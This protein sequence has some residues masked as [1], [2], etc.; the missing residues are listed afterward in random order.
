MTYLLCHGFGFTHEYWR[1]FVP[2]L[3]KDDVEF[4]DENFVPDEKKIYV[5]VG[6]SLGFLMLNNSGIKFH[7]LIGLQ[8]FLNFCGSDPEKN[9]MLKTNLDRMILSFKQ[10]LK[11]SLEFFYNFCGYGGSI[12]KNLSLEQLIKELE[13][14]KSSFEHCKA[15]TLIIGSY[16]D[17]VVEKDILIDN[18]QNKDLI[19]LKFLD[20]AVHS[21]G[22]QQPREVFNLIQTFLAEINE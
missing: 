10:D 13:M 8:G 16:D 20:K 5:G 7:A 6:H 12:P 11:R 19:T 18:F 22:Y 2:L 21:L 1:N 9:N 14:M 17:P 4:F 3:E 15:P